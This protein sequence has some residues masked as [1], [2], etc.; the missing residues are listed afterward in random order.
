M[1]PVPD[2][3]FLEHLIRRAMQ[4]GL[5]AEDAEDIVVRAWERAA[6]TFDPDR[7]S[8]EPY[9]AT[10]VDTDCRYF[11]RTWQR[12]ARRDFR[13]INEPSDPSTAQARERAAEN[14]QR[15]LDAF[16]ERERAVFATWAMQKHLPRGTLKAP[17]AAKS[18]G[19]SVGE[20]ENAQRRLR[21][22]INQ[23]LGA[24]GLQPR[25]LF[26]VEADERPRH[27]RSADG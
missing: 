24:W 6:A 2:A 26:S 3:R 18:L 25:D 10:L 22:R 4:R 16:D 27:K 8:F 12:R 20:W 21:T 11:W 19:V 1:A 5:P 15:L 17:D 14:Q 13:L 23:L 7:G 9:W